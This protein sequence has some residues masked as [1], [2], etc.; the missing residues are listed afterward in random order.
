MLRYAAAPVVRSGSRKPTTSQ[1][2][3]HRNSATDQVFRLACVSFYL[4]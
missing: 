1:A 3:G 2:R 4:M